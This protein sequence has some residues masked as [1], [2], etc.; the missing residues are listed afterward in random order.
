M[1]ASRGSGLGTLR[2]NS[3]ASIMDPEPMILIFLLSSP[4]SSIVT[5]AMAGCG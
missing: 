4:P 1:R 5:V 3:G 2:D